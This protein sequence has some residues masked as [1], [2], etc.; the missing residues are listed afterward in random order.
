VGAPLGRLFADAGQKG[1]A[2][3]HV[4]AFSGAF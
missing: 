1:V 3:G 2:V 4:N